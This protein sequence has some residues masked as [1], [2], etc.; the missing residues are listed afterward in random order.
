MATPSRPGADVA[1][2]FATAWNATGEDHA[3]AVDF[4]PCCRVLADAGLLD[5][6]E[7]SLTVASIGPFHLAV[8]DDNRPVVDFVE[9]LFP[10]V[11]AGAAAGRGVAGAV[12]GVLTAAC[13]TFVTLYRRGTVFGRSERDRLRWDVLTAVRHDNARTV[14]P[15]QETLVAA[16]ADRTDPARTDAAVLDAIEWLAGTRTSGAVPRSPLLVRQ[17]DGGLFATV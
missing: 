4:W 16:V 17:A 12:S 14:F 7:T 15:S 5:A 9:V 6:Q 11:I 10:A 8:S 3:L 2:A 1:E 13:T